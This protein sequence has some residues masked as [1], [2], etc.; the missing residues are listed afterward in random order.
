MIENQLIP[1]GTGGWIPTKY[2]ETA[3]YAFRHGKNL[4]VI[5]AG[6]GITRLFDP[7]DETLV[8][9]KEGI[10]RVYILLSHYH[11]DHSQGLFYL[12]GLFPDIPTYL[13]APGRGVYPREA[14]DMVDSIFTRPLTPRKIAELHGLMEINDLIVGKQWI[15]GL[16]ITTRVQDK[17]AD[18]S[19][20]IR[21]GDAFCYITDNIPEKESIVLAEGCGVLLHE[22]WYSSRDSYRGLD[23]NLSKHMDKGHSGSFGAVIIAKKA[24]VGELRFIHHNPATPVDKLQRIAAEASDIMPNTLLARDLLPIEIKL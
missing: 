5:D 19:M 11:L 7:T 20:G 18:P 15:G 17:H 16:Q 4:F 8:A 22:V 10:A 1:L 9:L 21:I 14:V 13:Y 3:C 12:K 24:G 2:F 23:D 6:S